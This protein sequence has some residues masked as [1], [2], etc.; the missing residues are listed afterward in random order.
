MS[1]A[2]RNDSDP[3]PVCGHDHQRCVQ[4]ALQRAETLCARRGVRLTELRQRV[5]ELVWQSHAPAGAYQIMEMLA[6]ERGRVAPPTVYR[7]LDFLAEQGLVHRLDSLSAFVGCAAPGAP[8]KA[9]FLICTSCRNAV[10]IHDAEIDAAL[11]SCAASRGFSIENETVELAGT[12][13]RCQQSDA[14]AQAHP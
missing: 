5:L 1:R 13:A 10:E 12:C 11:A 4:A 2:M 14:D 3:F 9:C 8:H 7:A 6:G